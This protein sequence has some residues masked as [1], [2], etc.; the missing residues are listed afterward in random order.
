[1]EYVLLTG[2]T[3]SIGSSIAISLSK[4][5]SIIMSGRNIEEINIVKSKLNGDGHLIWQCD[6]LNDNIS[7]SLKDFLELND[8]K[9]NHYLHIGGYFSISPIRLQKKEDTLKSFQVNVFSAIEI[10]R[11]LNKKEYKLKLKNILFFS[12]IS[13][14]RGKSG[15][16][17]YASAKS[18]LHGLM[19]SLAIELSPIKVNSIILGAVM[20]KTTENMLLDK[21]DF[22]N[23]H[24]PLGLAKDDVLNEW[25]NFLL[26]KKTWMTGQE[27]I[28]DGGATV[29]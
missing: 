11:V 3:S 7:Q 27:L 6:F 14:I 5:F 10:I 13:S 25:I 19:K 12:S 2:I 15:F 18:A 1:M 22:L 8:I 4:K 16:A 26:T 20:T 9:P 24:I 29:L 23:S 28:I 17:I 21:E